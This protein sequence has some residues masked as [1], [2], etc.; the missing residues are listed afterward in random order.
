M[1]K[2]QVQVGDAFTT[3][4]GYECKVIGYRSC[5]EV[6]IEFMTDRAYRVTTETKHVKT[7]AIKYPYKPTSH[8]KGYYGVGQYKANINNRKSIAYRK[9]SSMLKRCY[10]P[11]YL[12]NNPTYRDFHVCD[13]WLNFQNFAEWFYKQNE[14]SEYELDKDL[15]GDGEFYS[16]ETCCLIPCVI[17]SAIKTR[18]NNGIPSGVE[19]KQHGYSASITIEGKSKN[20]GIFNEINSAIKAFSKE[21]SLYVKNTAIKYKSTLKPEIYNAL[22]QWQFS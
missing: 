15:F 10:C 18:S 21:K 16:P 9:W 7:G 17:N 2:P 5:Q 3:N 22:M 13:E 11:N 14:P 19:R 1:T 6:D 4:E 20:L 8:G 12:N